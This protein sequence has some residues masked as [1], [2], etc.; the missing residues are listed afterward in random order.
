[1]AD[2]MEQ[3]IDKN[4]MKDSVTTK[5]TYISVVDIFVIP[6]ATPA[7]QESMAAKV[8]KAKQG[9]QEPQAYE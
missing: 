4:K 2:I 9:L 3:L 5:T 1:M 6:R 8:R 7:T